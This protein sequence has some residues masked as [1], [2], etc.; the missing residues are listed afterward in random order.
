MGDE[1][2]CCRYAD[3]GGRHHIRIT[4]AKKASN[5]SNLHSELLPTQYILPDMDLL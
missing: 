5:G 2:K 1:K 3:S 4:K